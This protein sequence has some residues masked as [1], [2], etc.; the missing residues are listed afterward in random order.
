M[1]VEKRRRERGWQSW[2]GTRRRG[3]KS[4]WHI[5]KCQKEK[6]INT[7]DGIKQRMNKFSGQKFCAWVGVSIAPGVLAWL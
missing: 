2:E 6:C 7:M 5:Q 4:I 3:R 1:N